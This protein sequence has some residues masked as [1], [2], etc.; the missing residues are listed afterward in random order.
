MNPPKP[1]MRDRE[2]HALAD[3]VAAVCDRN[4]LSTWLNDD[5]E[6]LDAALWEFAHP[7][8]A[9]TSADPYRGAEDDQDQED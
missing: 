3:E 9:G 8:L 4:G 5:R 2:F 7:D 1:P 6:R